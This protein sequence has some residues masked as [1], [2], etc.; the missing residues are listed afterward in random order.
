MIKLEVQV[1]I[2]S[3]YLINMTFICNLCLNFDFDIVLVKCF[4]IDN[5]KLSS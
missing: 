2:C 5:I 3:I 1:H 4:Q